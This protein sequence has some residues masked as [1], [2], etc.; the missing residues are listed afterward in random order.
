[1][2]LLRS[3]LFVPA[4][5]PERIPKA[6]G[7]GA[8]AVIVDLE[9]AVPADRK[10]EAR[11]VLAR[12]LKES[13]E[14]PRPP[15]FV[16][17]NAPGTSWLEE[18][19]EAVV[20]PGLAGIV[21]PK[22]ED[23]GEVRALDASSFSLAEKRKCEPPG[24]IPVVESALGLVRA[25]DIASASSRS[26]A[27]A[28]GGEDFARDLGA[29]RTPGG[30]ELSLARMQVVVA[31]R[32]AGVLPLD[33][34]YTHFR[35]EAG[36]ARDA[37]WAR[38]VGFAG[39]LLIHPRQVETVNRAF[40]PR[41]EDVGEARAVVSAFDAA[42]EKGEAVASLDGKM[43]DPAVVGQARRVVELAEEIARLEGAC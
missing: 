34:V 41:P 19:V 28:L 24:L 8:D 6:L 31:A 2:I 38:R 32:A 36:L 18:D 37:E 7:S 42:Q 17:V 9:D 16:R 13:A 22:A 4:T 29:V 43:L 27:L 20:L 21:L 15:L 10:A 1:M 14:P 35:D 3:L 5:T 39:K 26:L 33:T 12:F 30:E 25:F 23:P 40:S 11:D